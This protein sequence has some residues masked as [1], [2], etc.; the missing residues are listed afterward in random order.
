M[1]HAYFTS[2]ATLDNKTKW[3][4]KVALELR[5]RVRGRLG[6]A[7]AAKV[8]FF[9]V[10][11]GILTAKDWERE[12]GEAARQARV[13]VCFCSSTYFNSDYCA[14]EFEIFRRRI[15]IAGASNF[16]VI[17]PVVWD[18]C[19]VVPK[20]IARYQEAHAAIFPADY[21]L[22]GLYALR[23]N[24]TTRTSYDAALSA[25]TDVVVKAATGAQLPAL[26]PPIVFDQLPEAFDNPGPYNVRVAALHDAG[27]RW[28]LD[29]GLGVTLARVVE[30]VTATLRVP[31]RAFKVGDN[32]ESELAAAGLEREAVVFVAH[33]ATLKAGAFHVLSEKLD[34]HAGDNCVVV[35]A[36]EGVAGQVAPAEAQDRLKKLL[37]R[38]AGNGQVAWFPADV[39]SALDIRLT[40]EIVKLRLSLV[41][42]DPA[43]RFTDSSLVEAALQQGIGVD[44][45][46]VVTGPGESRT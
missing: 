30:K 3:L 26:P 17:I 40:E 23:R 5:D 20:A 15:K 24:K 14:K 10:H 36:L 27:L 1:T 29:P 22:Q 6:A 39:P 35:V 37:P 21:R 41:A 11:D 2:Y 32:L 38:L 43:E 18:I 4:G 25:L 31:W 7:D 13:L 33:D 8:G 42:A 44:A 28:E 19:S 9:A 46:P 12:L 34:A 45:R 16:D